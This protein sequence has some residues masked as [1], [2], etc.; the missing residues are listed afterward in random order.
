MAALSIELG[1]SVFPQSLPSHSE[2]QYFLASTAMV[3]SAVFILD[4]KGK[5]II[6]RNPVLHRFR[7]ASALLENHG[8]K[9]VSGAALGEI[10]N[11]KW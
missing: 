8:E 9:R 2:S 7:G 6:A 3:A 11:S 1:H 10:H 4:P 5:I